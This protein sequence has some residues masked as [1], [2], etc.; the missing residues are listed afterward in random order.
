[1]RLYS[2][3]QEPAT[4]AGVYISNKIG[5][6][7]QSHGAIADWSLNS[8]S[9]QTAHCNYD[10]KFSLARCPIPKYRISADTAGG[11]VIHSHCLMTLITYISTP[12]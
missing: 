7:C 12:R 5:V 1:M 10:Q 2:S 9:A 6:R 11:C 8:L 3:R 4:S